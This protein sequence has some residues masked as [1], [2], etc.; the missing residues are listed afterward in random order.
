[1]LGDN[2][3]S[4]FRFF[5]LFADDVSILRLRSFVEIFFKSLTAWQAVESV[6]TQY[7]AF[8]TMATFFAGVAIMYGL[9]YLVHLLDPHHTHGSN[10]MAAMIHDEAN[11]DDDRQLRANIDDIDC[12]S[13]RSCDDEEVENLPVSSRNLLTNSLQ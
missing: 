2:C 9:D 6:G 13:A 1:M 4:K 12:E 11:D 10:A 8:V 5:F 7:A 3:V